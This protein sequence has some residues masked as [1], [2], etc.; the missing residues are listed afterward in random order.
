MFKEI[1]EKQSAKCKVWKTLEANI[2][3][4]KYMSAIRER[5]RGKFSD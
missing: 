4:S 1:S 3:K 5:N 2:F